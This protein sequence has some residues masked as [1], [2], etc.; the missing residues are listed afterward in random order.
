MIFGFHSLYRKI[1]SCFS[2]SEWCIRLLKLSR[3]EQPRTARGIVLVQ[4]DGLSHRQALRAMKRGRLK[5]LQH[6]IEKEKY[7]MNLFYSGLPSSTPAVQAELFY[8]VEGAV[9]AFSFI[10]RESGRVFRM[11][12]PASVKAVERRLENLG[13]PLLEG[14]SAYCDIYT[15]GAR[16]AHFSPSALG[17]DRVIKEGP[18]AFSFLLVLLHLPTLVRIL[19]T[20]GIESVLAVYDF[21]SGI[22]KGEDFLK[23]L[24]FVPS[25]VAI[26]IFLRE[27]AVNGARIDTARGLPVIHLNLLGYDEQSHRRGPSSTFAHWTLKGIDGAIKRIWRAARRSPSR[28]YEVWIYSDHG[29]EDTRS[30]ARRNGV[31]LDEAVQMLYSKVRRDRFSPSPFLAR[32]IESQ[33]VQ[34][35]RSSLFKRLFPFRS[36]ERPAGLVPRVTAMGPLGMVYFPEKTTRRFIASFARKL[37]QETRIP[38]VFYKRPPDRVGFYTRSGEGEL[39]RDA[40]RLF[41]DNILFVDDLVED[42]I[43]L[44]YHPDAGDLVLSG[45]DGSQALTFPLENG[46]HAGFGPN[47]TRAFALL[48]RDTLL[49]SRRKRYLRP[50]DLRRSVQHLLGRV[51]LPDIDYRSRPA[52]KTGVFKL[53]T[54]NVHA[55]R[56]IDGKVH[57]E[58]I[59]RI[60]ASTRADIA[61]LQEIDVDRPQTGNVHQP[62]LLADILGMN[63]HFLPTLRFEGRGLYGIAIL[64]RF[65]IEVVRAEL[66]ASSPRKTRAE[67][68]GAQWVSIPVGNR[69][70]QVVNTHL[71]LTAKSRRRQVDALKGENWLAHPR[72]RAPAALCGDFNMMPRSP[73]FKRLLQSMKDVQQLAENHRPAGT[74]FAHYPF[75]R[76]DHILVTDGLVPR[77]VEVIDSDTARRA[78]DH[79]PLVAELAIA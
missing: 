35:F 48:P 17:F 74:W 76:I 78:S 65:P 16:E 28:D 36:H 1:R 27:I 43:R 26:S 2:L 63:Y 53:L 12:D 54:Y 32:G 64:S 39:P 47:E 22:L 14:G 3:S 72:F 4:V 45:P 75:A 77:K 10:E 44:C 18:K 30:Y 9:P 37:V 60:I 66:L 79:R 5:F 21:F 69:R 50:R 71:G 57:P 23:E 20:L 8:G 6:L 51:P 34:Y 55:C 29:Q 15:G 62:E 38:R 40:G 46:S 31:N 7:R 25:R 68:R 73:R 59:A 42:F 56:G 11:F 58:R 19:F 41:G 24:K 70:I 61:C 52:P 33:R 49:P 67:P 13:E